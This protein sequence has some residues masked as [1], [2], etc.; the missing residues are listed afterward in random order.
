VESKFFFGLNSRFV[1]AITGPS[2]IAPS[3][4]DLKAFS[5]IQKGVLEHFPVSVV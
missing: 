1:T 2:H 4:V 3:G 5:L